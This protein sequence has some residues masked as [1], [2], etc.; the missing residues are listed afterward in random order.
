MYRL[1]KISVRNMVKDEGSNG[2]ILKIV[3]TNIVV[4]PIASSSPPIRFK[5]IIIINFVDFIG[6]FEIDLLSE[7]VNTKKIYI[8]IYIMRGN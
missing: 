1:H 6:T 5:K 8:H 7:D 2:S 4:K 3:H